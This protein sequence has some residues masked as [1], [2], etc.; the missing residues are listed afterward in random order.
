MTGIDFLAD[1]NVLIAIKNGELDVMHFA[2]YW[3]EISCITEIE[4]LGWK[5]NSADDLKAY[6]GIIKACD[7]FELSNDIKDIAIRLK[8]K[9]NIKTPDAIIAATAIYYNIPLVS[10]DKGFRNIEELNHIIY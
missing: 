5:G 9:K 1:T 4:L 8:Q 7:V 3:I 10:R 6:K 2:E